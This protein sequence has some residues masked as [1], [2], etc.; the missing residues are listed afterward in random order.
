MNAAYPVEVPPSISRSTLLRGWSEPRTEP[1]RGLNIPI[2]H[3]VTERTS[4][5][6]SS[7]EHIPDLVGKSDSLIVRL[8]PNRAARATKTERDE[9]AL[10]LAGLDVRTNRRADWHAAAREGRII[11]LVA[12]LAT[13]AE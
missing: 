11:L 13:R 1:E 8:E 5:A 7:K 2:E 4:R 10:S 6:A 3:S 9:L 12:N